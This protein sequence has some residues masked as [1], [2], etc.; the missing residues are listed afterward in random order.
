M[1]LQRA[2]AVALRADQTTVRRVNLGVVLQHVS[3]AG[4]CSRA[5]IAAETGLTRGTVS[6]LVAELIDLELLRETGEDESP[7]RVG[8][9]AQTL[10]LA[11]VAVAVGLEVNVDYLAVSVEDLTGGI[12]YERRVFADNRLS[13]PGPVLDRLARMARGALEEAAQQRLLVVG[14]GV[15]VPGLVE[16]ASGSLLRAPNLG[17]T[18]LSVAEELR[19]RLPGLPLRVEN[20][21]NLAA[22]AEHWQGGVRGVRSFI[23]VFGEIGVGAG[24]FVDGELHRGAHG[25]GGEFGHIT[26][27]VEGPL[28]AC[29]SRG[30][31]ETFVGQEVIARAA[32]VPIASGGR[33][34]SITDELVRR[35]SEGDQAVLAELDAAGRSLGA[36]LASVVNLFDLDAVV[37]GGCFG[38]LSPWLV[39]NVRAALGQRVLSAEWSTCEVYASALGELAAVRGAAALMLRDVLVAPWTVAE[40]RLAAGEAAS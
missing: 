1:T 34:R 36:A 30:C 12:R 24:I 23:C 11:D 8:R 6:S 7:G 2:R 19:R 9:P 5:R 40:R 4:A 21:A 20:E 16:V 31:L 25:F 3:A 22:L 32:G 15:A 35:A 33:T 39:G 18:R 29:G 27:D 26:V 14:I 13:A 10:E 38:P 28:C 17:W 37:L